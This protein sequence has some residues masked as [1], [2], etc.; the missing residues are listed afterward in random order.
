MYYRSL[1]I[2]ISLCF[3]L[4]GFAQKD[5][6]KA[7]ADDDFENIKVEKLSTAS[8]ASAFLIWVK[9]TVKKHYHAEHT[10]NLYILEGEGRF[11]LG[12]KIYD[13]KAG[14]YFQI[15]KKTIHSVKVKSRIPLKALSVQSPEFFGKDRVFVD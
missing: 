14:D 15:P 11:Y 12:D 1:I 8:E 2:L 4:H 9:D 13:I 5:I 3:S 6:L 7:K 10:E